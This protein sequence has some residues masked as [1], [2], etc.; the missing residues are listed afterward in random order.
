MDRRDFLRSAGIVTATVASTGLPTERGF[1]IA[2]A[3]CAVALAVA[4]L[5]ALRIPA[6]VAAAR[7]ERI[8]EAA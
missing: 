3:S 6:P 7:N 4:F 5:V 1:T 8:L 2:F